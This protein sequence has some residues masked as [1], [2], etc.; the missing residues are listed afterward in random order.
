MLTGKILTCVELAAYVDEVGFLPLLPFAGMPG[1][2]AEEAVAPECRYR[3]LPDGGWEWRLWDWKGSILRETG[4]GYGK[5]L[6]GQALFVSRAW[7]PHFYNYRR[8]LYPYPE[9]GSI[10]EAILLTLREKG[11]MTSRELRRACGLMQPGMRG[12]FNTYLQHLQRG[13]YVVIEDFVFPRDKKGQEYGWGWSKLTTPEERF[14]RECCKVDCSP[15][16]SRSLIFN[17]LKSLMP[18]EDEARIGRVLK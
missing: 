4:C 10:E 16:D 5:F 3:W 12:K 9:E 17:Q 2:S 8:W 6:R 15:Q 18:G 13:G 7:W 1:W 14:G 11:S